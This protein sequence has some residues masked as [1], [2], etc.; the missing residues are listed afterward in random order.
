M[1][2]VMST[3][4]QRQIVWNRKIAEIDYRSQAAE[5]RRKGSVKTL[6]ELVNDGLLALP[7]AVRRSGLSEKEFMQQSGLKG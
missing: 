2:V 7:E 4:D 1:R 5:E 3:P 6:G